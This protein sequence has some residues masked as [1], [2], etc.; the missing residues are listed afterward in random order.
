VSAYAGVDTSRLLI[1]GMKVAQEN[2]RLI[3][4]NVANVDTPNYTP[5]EMDF[6]AALRASLGGK[7]RTQLRRTRPQ[8]FDKLASRPQFK[9]LAFLSRN[10]YNK[11]NLDD[12]MAKLAENTGRYVTYGSLLVKQFEQVKAM[13]QQLR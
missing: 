6:Q 11:V 12:Q 8:H 2:H 5:I 13:L 7:G 10:D 9:R 1:T 4:N 3:A